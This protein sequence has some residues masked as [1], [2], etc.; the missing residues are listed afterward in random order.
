MCDSFSVSRKIIELPIRNV[1]FYIKKQLLL[2]LQKCVFPRKTNLFH[3]NF[4]FICI[5]FVSSHL[6]NRQNFKGVMTNEYSI[7]GTTLRQRIEVMPEDCILF[8]SD[9]PEYHTEFVGSVLS[10]LTAEDGAV[11]IQQAATCRGVPLQPRLGI[12]ED[13]RDRQIENLQEYNIRIF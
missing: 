4:S 3:G 1:V 6:K 2:P 8:R 5:V 13:F 10:E 9:F 7:E 11:K 12:Q